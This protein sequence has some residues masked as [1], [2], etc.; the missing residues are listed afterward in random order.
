M[1]AKLL[2]ALAIGLLL[3]ADAP[4]EG[5]AVQEVERA[6]GLLNEAF[7]KQDAEAIKRLT[8]AD[9]FAITGY[10]GGAQTRD[11]QLK[12]LKDLKLT[13]YK[14]G[15]L[16]VT[17]L[18]KDAALV[19]YPL[20]LKGTFQGKTVPWRNFASAV[21]VRREGQWREAFYQETSLAGE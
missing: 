14:A 19:T 15:K 13:E 21:W 3:G 8:T 18:G 17:L 6:L 4:Q 10:Y 5:T 16:K 12:S 2:A 20:S 1:K 7:A 11:E 9:H